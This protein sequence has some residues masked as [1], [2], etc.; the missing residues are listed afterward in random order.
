VSAGT[1]AA[2]DRTKLAPSIDVGLNGHPESAVQL[3]VKPVALPELGRGASLP[4]EQFQKPIDVEPMLDGTG[5]EAEWRHWQL[6][7]QRAEEKARQ[8]ERDNLT[9]NL[10]RFFQQGARTGR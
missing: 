5:D 7:R 9:G 4:D 6:A 1:Q 10:Q 8:A 3:Q 2:S